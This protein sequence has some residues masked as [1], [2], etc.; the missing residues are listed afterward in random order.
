MSFHEKK[1]GMAEIAFK[2]F[3]C[4]AVYKSILNG[5]PGKVRVILNRNF[6]SNPGALFTGISEKRPAVDLLYRQISDPRKGDTITID[7]EKFT[8]EKEYDNDHIKVKV[9]VK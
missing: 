2:K 6:D 5:V 1:Q 4:D 8:V 7:G 9:L 3:G